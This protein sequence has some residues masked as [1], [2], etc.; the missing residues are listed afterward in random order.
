[1]NVYMLLMC[2]WYTANA[3]ITSPSFKR[4]HNVSLSDYEGYVLAVEKNVYN[5]IECSSKCQ[6]DCLSYSYNKD[7]KECKTYTKALCDGNGVN[8][9]S[10]IQMYTKKGADSAC[11]SGVY[12]YTVTGLGGPTIQV[13][14][15][16]D[17][18][19]GPWIRRTSADVDFYRN[20]A[21]YKNGFGNLHGNFWL[22]NDNIHL[23]TSTPMILRVEL[24]G[25]Y[26][27]IVYAQY[28]S[29]QIANET[30]NY[31]LAIAGFSGS[32][33]Y[34]ALAV[35][36]GYDFTTYDRDN[37]VHRQNCASVYKGAW[38]YTDCHTCNLNGLY[39][40]DVGETNVTS[41]VWRN[42]PRSSIGTPLKKSTMMIRK[43]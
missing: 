27:K 39:M 8:L 23:L 37:D 4:E 10:V 24:E 6:T 21:D 38:W 22:G 28:S 17:T 36:D 31:R 16:V 9:S 34:N 29:F 1:M 40:V 7:T 26:G 30:Q 20:W 43:P 19:D 5:R 35:H 3:T 15:D 42:F 32:V 2:F 41:M 12:D 25:W 11:I 18:A 13:Y 33:S 14:L